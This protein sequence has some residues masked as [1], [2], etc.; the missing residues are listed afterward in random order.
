MSHGRESERQKRRLARYRKHDFHEGS[1]RDHVQPSSRR[2]EQ[3]RER[4]H[5]AFTE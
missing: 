1:P 2:L 3:Y 4:L 5:R